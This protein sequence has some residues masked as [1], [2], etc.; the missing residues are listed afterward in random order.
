MMPDPDKPEIDPRRKDPPSP[1]PNRPGFLPLPMVGSGDDKMDVMSRLLKDRILLLGQ[2]SGLASQAPA[3][4]SL[5]QTVTPPSPL[6][7]P[8]RPQPQPPLSF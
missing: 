2:V 1:S 4:P 5:V 3:P 6:N 7:T 8:A